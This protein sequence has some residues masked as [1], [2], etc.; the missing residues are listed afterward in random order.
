MIIPVS[1]KSIGYL[2]S[3][4]KHRNHPAMGPRGSGGSGGSA[5]QRGRQEHE[6]TWGT[7]GDK[8]ALKEKEAKIEQHK[9]AITGIQKEIK[10]PKNR[11]LFLPGKNDV[12]Y[13]PSFRFGKEM[14]AV[15]S[16]GGMALF[17]TTGKMTGAEAHSMYPSI[18][19]KKMI[20]GSVDTHG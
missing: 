9:T 5:G 8:R 13:A 4:E 18:L 3:I 20:V 15:R 10:D 17:N 1:D 14:Y 2:F 11:T 12:Y 7:T 16:P 19:D 6:N